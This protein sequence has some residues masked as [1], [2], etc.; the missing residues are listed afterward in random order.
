MGRRSGSMVVLAPSGTPTS[1]LG[2]SERGARFAGVKEDRERRGRPATTAEGTVGRSGRG[3]WKR[4]RTNQC[5]STTRDHSHDS[6]RSIRGG[7]RPSTCFV[8]TAV[9]HSR[10]ELEQH[11]PSRNCGG[12]VMTG[13]SNGGRGDRTARA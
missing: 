11:L 5:E 8:L 6:A 9:A 10:P 12:G 7:G 3:A 13:R 2:E 4:E 1:A